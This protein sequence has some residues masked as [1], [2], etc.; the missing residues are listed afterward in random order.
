[1]DAQ[2][3]SRIFGAR[4]MTRGKPWKVLLAFSLPLLLGNMFQQL[5]NTVDSIVVGRYVG[6]QAL[7]A[8][9]T[10]FPAMMLMLA[11]FMGVSTGTGIMVSQYFGAK[12]NESLSK[13]VHTAI[14]LTVIVGVVISVAGYFFVPTLLTWLNTPADVFPMA[15]TYLRIIFLGHIASLFYNILAGILRGLGDS[16]TPL[17]FLIIATLLNIVLDLLFVVQFDMGVAGVAW[18]TII[19]QAVS[20]TFGFVRLRQMGGVLHIR[21]KDL[22]PDRMIAARM[23]RLGLPAGIQ[24]ATF[25]VANLLVQGLINGFG[26]V[27]MAGTNIVMRVDMFA[28]MPNFT[29]GMAMTTYS[30]QNVGAR[31]MDRVLAGVK[32][33]LK[34]GLGV[35][36]GLTVLILVF[37][38]ALMHLFTDDQA[39]IVAGMRML[40][41]V[42]CGYLGVT[43]NQILSGVMRGAGDTAVPMYNSLITMILVRLP[44]AF[45]VTRMTGTPDGI[46]YS[47]LAAWML[48]A[49]HIVWYYLRGKWKNKS[50]VRTSGDGTG[51][52]TIRS[53]PEVPM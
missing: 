1:M 23:I 4:D 49:V 6:P 30:G 31:R 29:F 42:A 21:L 36:A 39:V 35:S 41:I 52:E 25:S 50:V 16:I 40:Y 10:S 11:L 3:R 19:S 26:Y 5:Y 9:G 34:L 20:A 2:T 44:I 37:G 14:S 48:G 32:D 24:Q 12:D 17:V 13:T 28:M 22:K 47:L 27:V 38:K 45:A 53:E 7:A 46:Y 51:I 33:G 15:E 43:V 8:V 18:A